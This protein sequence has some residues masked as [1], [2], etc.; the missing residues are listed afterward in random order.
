MRNRTNVRK[1]RKIKVFKASDGPKA[2]VYR[3]M[4]AIVWDERDSSWNWPDDPN[5]EY[6]KA[7]QEVID[8]LDAMISELCQHRRRLMEDLKK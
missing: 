7:T 8:R 5:V 3:F 2:A 6:Q 4:P 1:I